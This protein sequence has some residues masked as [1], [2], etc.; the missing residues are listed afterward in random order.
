MITERRAPTVKR[1]PTERSSVRRL[2]CLAGG[3]VAL[4]LLALEMALRLWLALFAPPDMRAVYTASPHSMRRQLIF[5]GA[6]YVNYVLTPNYQSG[7]NRHNS[8]GYRGAEIAVPKPEGVFRI[9]ALGG[10]TTYGQGIED[11]RLAYPAQLERILREDYGYAGVEVVNAGVHGYA[12]WDSLANF[13]F[14]VLDLEPDLIIVYHGINDLAARMVDPAYYDGLNRARGVWQEAPDLQL[15]IPSVLYRLTAIKLGWMENPTWLLWKLEEMEPIASCPYEQTCVLAGLTDG[16][17]L[18]ANPPLYF[19]RNLRNL[20]SLA[21][22]NDVQV[23]LSSWAY[24]PDAIPGREA[25]GYMTAPFRQEGIAEQNAILAELASTMGVNYYDL[26][27]NMPYATAYWIDGI[28]V[29]AA[30]AREQ[31]AE[32]AAFLVEQGL[33]P[34][35]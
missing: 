4:T 3:S 35:D 14:R 34:D 30:G 33:L 31:A 18:A 8:L 28:H 24:F 16:E 20:I 12:S 22:A 11:W 2:G 25:G 19:E 26:L 29:T 6:P 23:A 17:I 32:Y 1:S 15:Y 21:Q 7:L 27:A 10:S 9:V 13:A 5:S